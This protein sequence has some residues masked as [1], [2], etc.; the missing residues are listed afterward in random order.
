[1]DGGSSRP[2]QWRRCLQPVLEH[3]VLAR[4]YHNYYHS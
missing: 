1:M 3:I 4:F 2:T